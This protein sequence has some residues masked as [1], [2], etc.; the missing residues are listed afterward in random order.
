[1]ALYDPADDDAI[2]DIPVDVI[3]S[4]DDTGDIPDDLYDYLLDQF[5]E[6]ARAMGHD[7]VNTPDLVLSEWTIKA[8]LTRI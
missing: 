4:V 5:I 3:L 8:R 1:M 2:D 6:K 7:V